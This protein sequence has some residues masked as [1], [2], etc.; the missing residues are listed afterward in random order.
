M[1]ISEWLRGLDLAQ[2][3]PIFRENAIDADILPELTEADLEKLGV[4]LGHRKRMLR[5][6][7]ARAAA[8]PAAAPR[9]EGAERRHLT[10]MF[11]DLVGSTALSARLDPEDL[12]EV[13][14]AYHAAVAAEVERFGGFVARYMGDGVLIYFGYPQAHE[15]DVERAL[16]AGLALVERIARLHTGE[17]TLAIRIGIATGLVVVGDMIGSG[18]AQEW[19]IVGETPN[20]ASRLQE[21]AESNTVV[22]GETTRRLVGDLFEC[23]DLGFVELKG[24][25]NKVSVSQVL[26]PSAVESRFEALRAAELSPLVGREEETDLLLQRWRRAKNG[27]GQLVLISGEAGI[28]KSRLALAL[29][30]GCKVSRIRG[31]AILVRLITA[32]ARSTPLSPSSSAPQGSHAKTQPPLGST[33]S[34]MYWRR[35][36]PPQ[37]T[38]SRCSPICWGCR[39]SSATRLC[40]RTRSGG[41]S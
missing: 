38:R 26:R 21:M 24:L 22:V 41:A 39:S 35:P 9:A 5:A 32:T 1:D 27:H 13:L 40:R 6:I 29:R 19:D 30:T 17:V 23:R 15:N 37:V 11:C 4:L 14:G 25:T 33:S 7:A 8:T 2:Y 16:H 18:E 10:V 3:E 31:S 36:I 34:N 20:L 28:G 12:R